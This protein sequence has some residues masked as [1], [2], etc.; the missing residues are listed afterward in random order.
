MVSLRPSERGDASRR[1]SLLL[2][3]LVHLPSTL[4]AFSLSIRYPLSGQH[5]HTIST[6][7]AA[8]TDG[9]K[10]K[11]RRKKPPAVPIQDPVKVSLEVV[12]GLIEDETQPLTEAD[13]STISD[14]ARFEFQNDKA[15]SM[16]ILTEDLD[17]ASTDDSAPV[18]SGAIPLPDIREA[19]KRKQ[20]E[21]EL[22][23]EAQEKEE[24]KVK[25]KRTDKEAFRRV[26]ILIERTF[27]FLVVRPDL[28][29]GLCA[30]S[31]SPIF[32]LL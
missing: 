10:K 17:I 19:R 21:E 22:A 25:I 30:N 9:E 23:R 3:V 31:Y 28:R 13:L 6:F 16:S 5:F 2:F 29:C 32:T 7:L 15:M 11:R 1:F 18:V 4:D 24:Q 26:S 8:A 12:E 20:L 14:I 27:V